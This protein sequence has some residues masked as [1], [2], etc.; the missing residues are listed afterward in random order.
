MPDNSSRS[1]AV[2]MGMLLMI[3]AFVVIGGFMYWLNGQA[4]AERA[5]RVVEEVVEEPV[6]PDSRTIAAEEIQM[7]ATPFEGQEIR[8]EGI[9]VASLLG[10]QGFWLEMPN[11]NPFLVSMSAEVMA[12]GVAVSQGSAATVAGT[13]KAM[14]EVTLVAW[15]SAGTISDNDRIVA[16]FA[17][18]FLDATE[19][20][21][22]GGADAE[23]A[24]GAN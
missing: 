8:L 7:D 12:S 19:V 21:I 17:T 10:T 9:N 23:G 2:D 3:V 11:G 13:I 6:G 15:S 22:E 4:A 14:D 1:G 16:E 20:E 5:L 24:A 18:H